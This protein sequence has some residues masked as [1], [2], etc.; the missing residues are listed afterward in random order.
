[1]FIPNKSKIFERLV[2]Q[3]SL[4]KE[5]AQIF[6]KLTGDWKQLAKAAL[7]L[8]ELEGETDKFVH[9]ITDDIEKTF[10][11]PLDKEDIKE[12]TESLDD[13][14]DNLEQSVNCLK[15]Y[16]I[17]RSNPKLREFSELIMKAASLIHRGI[18]MVREHKLGSA[19]YASC[20]KELHRLENQGDKLH[21]LALANLFGLSS[22]EFNGKDAL[23]I[24][25]WK[26]IFQT[27]ED[28]LDRCE[29]IAILL[30]KLRIKYR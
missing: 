8:E 29:D 15:I 3:S 5:A 6:Y 1:M 19:G 20:Y 30:E 24:I 26:E 28:T 16:K 14:I 27:L 7:S 22:E 11:L 10:I 21:R 23:S 25:K 18:L 9:S 13:V 17:K 2:K 4:V 12:L